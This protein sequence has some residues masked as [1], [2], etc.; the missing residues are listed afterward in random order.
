MQIRS[1]VWM[2]KAPLATV[3]RPPIMTDA[4]VSPE[5]GWAQAVP[6]DTPTT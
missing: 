5:L 2:G 1:L 3:R 4:T 6:S